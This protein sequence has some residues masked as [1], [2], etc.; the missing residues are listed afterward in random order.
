[1]I[2]KCT[3]NLDNID[4]INTYGDNCGFCDWIAEHKLSSPT[5]IPRTGIM[6]AIYQKRNI[7][8]N[9]YLNELI[10]APFHHIAKNA[11]IGAA[12]YYPIY[13]GNKLFG[14][15]ALYA[16]EPMFFTA[17]VQ[18][19]L[20]EMA[21]DVSFAIDNLR[22]DKQLV[23]SERL[24]HN[25]TSFVQVGI[26]RLDLSGQL[27]Y[28]NE[29]GSALLQ[30]ATTTTPPDQWL[31]TIASGDRLKLQ[32]EW[33]PHLLKTG[34]SEIEVHAALANDQAGWLTIHAIAETN[35]DGQTIGYIGTLTN[36]TK[37]KETEACLKYQAHYDPLTRLPNRILLAINLQTAVQ[38]S[39][40][41]NNRMALLILDLDRFKDVNDSF[42]HHMGDVLLQIV[43]QRLQQ[44]MKMISQISRLGGDEF[45]ILLD[46]N[47][48][49]ESIN[50]IAEEIIQLMKKPF[51]LPNDRDVMLGA[52]IGISVYPD[53]GT[54]PEELLQKA[55]AAMYHAKASGRSC[56]R[57]FSAE[58]TGLADQRLDME[59]RLKRAIEQKELVVFYQPQID[60]RTNKVIGAEALVRWQDP[61]HGLIPPFK[62]IPLAEET[63]LIKQIGEW[64][65][66]ET[67]R[68]GKHW[69][70]IGLPPL[71][72]AVN[73]SPIQFHY[74][75][76]F[77]V[78]T[79]TL[80]DTEFPAAYLELEL[81]E[82]ALMD[83]EQEAIDILNQLQ[84]EGVRLAID[85][86]GTGY[87]SLSYL[88]RL[89]LDVLKIDKS[90]VDDIPNSKD[91]MEIAA[92]IVGIAHTL[93][94]KVLAEGVETKEQF[95]F[96][97]EQGCDMYQGYLMSKPIPADQ[98]EQ[99]LRE[100][101]QL[102][103]A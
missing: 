38:V 56:F 11:N 12:G 43:T 94:L 26:F 99:L 20:E 80:H 78:V 69:L 10:T 58:L 46:N 82:S 62:F 19:T 53:H 74:N 68:Q 41:N 54:T 87:S 47:P 90:F 36:I 66:Q 33:L 35:S 40:Q 86:F 34:E 73:I 5:L 23:A 75:D 2:A 30:F 60:M 91:D 28:I 32:H 37:I 92:T 103:S 77:R 31:Q 18:A 88:K 25:L 55:D 100:N 96:L 98:F 39:Q 71:T 1:M 64:V 101:H 57:Y 27:L 6:Q 83:R 84:A 48:T 21:G 13:D 81:T 3:P 79:N 67:C 93:R 8:I 49:N 14:A 102:P 9:D 52:S 89:P 42:G 65:L 16:K 63:G 95:A 50:T 59:V 29:F 7:V 70:D 45:T 17:Q 61:E 44:H 72:L 22:R 4:I 97:K 51:R 76:L 24:F 85:D 15:L